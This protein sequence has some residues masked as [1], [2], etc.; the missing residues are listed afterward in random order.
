MLAQL[1]FDRQFPDDLQG[2][3]GLR[4]AADGCSA[5]VAA[6]G[7]QVISWQGRDGKE[8]LYLSADSGGM[9][10]GDDR[11]ALAAAI[12]GGVPVCFPQFSGRGPMIKH[13]FARGIGWQR[14]EDGSSLR[15]MLTDD[16]RSRRHWPH[17]FLAQV[18]VTLD[19]DSLTVAL[20]VSNR[21]SR[22]WSFTCALHTYFRV[23]DI[24]STLLDGLQGIHYQDAT[25]D[26][27]ERVQ[28]EQ[29]LA[30]PGEVDRVYLAPPPALRLI[31][32]GVPTLRIAQQGFADTVVW[33]PGPELARTL[34]DFPDQDWL[35]ML[36]VEAAHAAAP[37]SLE[38]GQT[39]H[40][41]QTLSIIQNS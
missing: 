1:D 26:N 34:K 39:W 20:E 17:A 25:A 31:E 6:Q 40:G 35:R 14:A 29:A 21:D 32:N 15:L 24:R 41:S 38:P 23:D 12:R 2:L 4:I 19:A 28:Q 37:V 10:R 18:A 22:P 16:E 36:C 3:P 7:G 11:N 30:I 13:G 9:R 33:N 8:R 5:F 27:I